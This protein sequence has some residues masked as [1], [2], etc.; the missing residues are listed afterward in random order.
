[1]GGWVTLAGKDNPEVRAGC[2]GGAGEGLV[3]GSTLK[4]GQLFLS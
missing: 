4:L 3:G 2:L 1:M